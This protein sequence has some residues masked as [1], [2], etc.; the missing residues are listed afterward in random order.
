MTNILNAKTIFYAGVDNIRP[1]Y[2]TVE[3]DRKVS[4]IL[5]A[6]W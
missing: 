4:L 2:S 1:W 3:T 6:S 5:R